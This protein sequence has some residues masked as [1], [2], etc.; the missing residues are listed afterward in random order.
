M[1]KPLVTLIDDD[2]IVT[3]V[4]ER[5]L[6]KLGCEVCIFKNTQ[7]LL[8]SL[9][10]NLPQLLILDL[11]LEGEL[12][13]LNLIR[14]I[15]SIHPLTPPIIILSGDRDQ[16]QVIQGIELGAND[17]IIKPPNR[18]D[19]EE[20]I[21]KWVQFDTDGASGHGSFQL[22]HPDQGKAI[23]SFRG[24]IAEVHPKG[25]TLA[26]DHLIKKSASFYIG[27]SEVQKVTPT[28]DRL[29][30]SVTESSSKVISGHQRYLIE[31]EVDPSYEQ[32]LNEIRSFLATKLS[33][34]SRS[35]LD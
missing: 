20:T 28:F 34:Q 9:Q 1:K 8:T 19:F 32:A 26:V 23:L 6:I 35:D 22:V 16:A 5:R 29:L 15:R 3:Q 27:G 25:F 21:S 24:W 17:Y 30:V 7:L 13:G 14:Q 31:L 33:E 4:I 18:Y 11:H 12:S 2:D 10:T